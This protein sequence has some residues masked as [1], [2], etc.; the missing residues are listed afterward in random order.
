VPRDF[1]QQLL[2]AAVLSRTI[3]SGSYSS[4]QRS[5]VFP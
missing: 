2:T 3:S 1:A 5:T 4:C